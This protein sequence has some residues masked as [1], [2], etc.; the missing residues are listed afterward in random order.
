MNFLKITFEEE[1]KILK[2]HWRD[3]GEIL[4]KRNGIYGFTSEEAE[5]IAP[6]LEKYVQMSKQ[7][8]KYQHVTVKGIKKRF[9]VHIDPS[10]QI[11]VPSQVPSLYGRMR[12]PIKTLD[13]SKILNFQT[14]EDW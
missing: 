14:H 3:Y 9:Y 2:S 10:G 12:K 5:K 7:S 13:N 8:G 1:L 4:M 11:R 6:Q